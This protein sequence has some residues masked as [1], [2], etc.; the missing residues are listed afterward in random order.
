MRL[1]LVED[2]VALADELLADLTRQGYAVDW[3]ADGRD[4]LVQ[5]ATEPYDLVVLDLGLPGM[6]GLDVL[7]QW[8]SDGLATPVLVLTARGSWAERI[9]GLKAGADDYLS[10]PFHPEEL[11]LRIQALLRRAHGLANQSELKAAG[12]ALDEARQCV[13]RGDEE[14]PL[15]AG[16]FRLLRYFMLHPGQ[17]LSKTQLNDHI[18][19]GESERDSNVIEVHVNHLRRKLGREVIE[20]RRGQGYR[21][22]G[23]AEQGG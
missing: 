1:L 10:K 4:A 19:D 18:Y 5:G 2:N 11:A 22:A 9:D 7:R 17:I 3:L 6:P 20:T 16:E 21:Y 8:R 23:D 12:L 14:V 15:T 13:R